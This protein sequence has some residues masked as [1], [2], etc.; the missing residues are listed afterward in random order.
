[1]VQRGTLAFAVTARHLAALPAEKRKVT[2]GTGCGARTETETGPSLAAVLRAGDGQTTATTW[3]D[4]VSSG[5]TSA[6]VT[7]A[8]ATSGGRPL[9]VSL[10]EDGVAL[11]SP[12]L[13]ADGDVRDGRDV[14]DLADLDIGQGDGLGVE[15]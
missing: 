11:P 5:G 7:P 15:P 4:A 2:V 12:R 14:S 10:T 13:V 1:V 8:E 6:I 9:I 3:V